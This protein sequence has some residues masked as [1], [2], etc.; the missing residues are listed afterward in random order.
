MLR[1]PTNGMVN[2]L[3]LYSGAGGMSLGLENAGLN[4]VA[5]VD[6]DADAVKTYND[7]FEHNGIQ[8][9]LEK[10]GPKEFREKYDIRPDNIDVISGGPPCQGFSRSNLDKSVND[11]RNNLVF[12]F[13]DYVKFY[14]PEKFIME[15]V[16][17]LKSFNGG[18]TLKSLSDEFEDMKYNVSIFELNAENYGV[19]QSR[20]RLFII[21]DKT[22]N[23][24]R[25]KKN[26][27]KIPV[28]D[29]LENIPNDCDNIER[30]HNAETVSKYEHASAGD[31]PHGGCSP[32]ILYDDRPSWTITVS[33]GKTPIHPHEP[34]MLTPREIARIQSFPDDFKFSGATG[35]TKK[36]RQV[37]NAVPPKLAKAIGKSI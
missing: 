15:N 26:D 4:V 25:P 8:E 10:V 24:K 17:G 18:N 28:S 9:N 5:G 1:C 16:A 29:V 35:R 14:K 37:G 34:R 11:S 20:K 30:N 22:E 19:A 7:N 33:D 12:T 31:T 27:K 2:V 36:C 23:P 6:Y 3:D 21:G 32:R 13:A